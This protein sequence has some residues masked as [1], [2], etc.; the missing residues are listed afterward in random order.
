M[1]LTKLV[2][3][4]ILIFLLDFILGLGL[5]FSK[6]RGQTTNLEGNDIE[7]AVRAATDLRKPNQSEDRTDNTWELAEGTVD[8]QGEAAAM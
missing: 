3:A 5:V 7:E 2:N 6:A 1:N 4:L 8:I